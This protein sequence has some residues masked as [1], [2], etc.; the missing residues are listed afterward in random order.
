MPRAIML[1]KDCSMI[2]EK[3]SVAKCRLSKSR[4]RRVVS[5][6]WLRL[7][8]S[9]VWLPLPAF[10]RWSPSSSSLIIRKIDDL[11]IR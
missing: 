6:A 8:L 5:R 9:R 3:P 10:T 2:S 1:S 4:M 11:S 7:I